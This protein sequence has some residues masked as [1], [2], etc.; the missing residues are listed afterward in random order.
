[1]ARSDNATCALGDTLYGMYERR[2]AARFYN[3]V[4]SYYRYLRGQSPPRRDYSR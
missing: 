3:A 4:A 2:P 1:V